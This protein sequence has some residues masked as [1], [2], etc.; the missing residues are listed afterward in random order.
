MKKTKLSLTDLKVSSF[1]TDSKS[2][3]GG[4]ILQTYYNCPPI[5]VL[6]NNGCNLSW[7]DACHS[8]LYPCDPIDPIGPI[9]VTM[10]CSFPYC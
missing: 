3:K 6:T 5:V 9:D 2:V 10:I 7:V 8:A 1:V 4:T